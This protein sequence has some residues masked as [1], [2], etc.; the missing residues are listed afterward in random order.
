[1]IKEWSVSKSESDTFFLY[2]LKI[3]EH[4][5]VIRNKNKKVRES[6]TTKE[7]ARNRGARL[8]FDNQPVGSS[9]CYPFL[10]ASLAHFALLSRSMVSL[11]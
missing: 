2:K 8:G 1:M 10:A 6:S 5:L 3:K 11:D 9:C 7:E 4:L